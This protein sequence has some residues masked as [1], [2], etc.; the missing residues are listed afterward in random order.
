MNRA[1][2]TIRQAEGEDQVRYGK[3]DRNEQSSRDNQTGGG[4]RCVANDD[5]KRQSAR[6]RNKRT[7]CLS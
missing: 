6:N 5:L 1:V 3:E 2:E 4:Q 7:K